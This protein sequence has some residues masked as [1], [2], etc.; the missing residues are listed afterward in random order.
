MKFSIIF[1]TFFLN[2]FQSIKEGTFEKNIS[3]PIRILGFDYCRE[4]QDSYFI[5][6]IGIEK[7]ELQGSSFEREDFVIYLLKI[8]YKGDIIWFNTYKTKYPP[9]KVIGLFES[10]P[11][12]FLVVT[13]EG[14]TDIRR[15]PPHPFYTVFLKVNH[16]GKLVKQIPFLG[17]ASSIAKTIDSS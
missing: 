2:S 6:G 15:Q 3:V 16:D 13:L 7:D 11:D 5:S 4:F 17:Q 12:L 9:S 10:G 8:N 14:F 1:I